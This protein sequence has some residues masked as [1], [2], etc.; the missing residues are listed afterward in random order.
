MPKSKCRIKSRL[1]NSYQ[2]DIGSEAFKRVFVTHRN[3][4]TTA[5]K[6]TLKRI[7]YEVR[8]REEMLK[9]YLERNRRCASTTASVERGRLI[10]PSTLMQTKGRRP[11]FWRTASNSIRMAT[12][13]LQDMENENVESMSL[14]EEMGQ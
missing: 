2:M 13:V 10:R 14:E 1:C 8:E 5:V 11:W 3:A 7:D 12:D 4:V 9:E 6:I